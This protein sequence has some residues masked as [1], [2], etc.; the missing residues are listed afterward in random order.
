MADRIVVRTERRRGF[1]RAGAWLTIIGLVPL[2]VGGVATWAVGI[3][4]AAFAN[5]RTAIPGTLSFDGDGGEYSL[6]L[7]AAPV[8]AVGPDNVVAQVRC[9]VARPDGSTDTVDGSFAVVR[10]ETDAGVEIGR[11][12]TT[13][14]TTSVDCEWRNSGHDGYFASVAPTSSTFS[15]VSTALLVLGIVLL[16]VASGLLYIG[17]RGRAVTERIPDVGISGEG[18]S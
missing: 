7:I 2:L 5:D 1:I 12:T 16:L 9:D 8:I 18:T 4:Q 14:G 6:L 3:G 17:F 15:V 13:A 11:F 10:T